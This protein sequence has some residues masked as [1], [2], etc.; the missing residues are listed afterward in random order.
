M[1]PFKANTKNPQK[2]IGGF[3]FSNEL[4][5]ITDYLTIK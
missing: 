1:L 3:S 5:Q 4:K 2:I